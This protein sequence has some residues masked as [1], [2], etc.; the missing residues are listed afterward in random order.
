MSIDVELVANVSSWRW[1][2]IPVNAVAAVIRRFSSPSSL[3]RRIDLSVEQDSNWREL[4][5]VTPVTIPLCRLPE[6]SGRL[7]TRSHTLTT[8]SPLEEASTP[9]LRGSLHIEYTPS[10]WPSPRLPSRGAA[11]NL[12]NF[13]ALSALVYSLALSCGCSAGLRDL[14]M[15]ECDVFVGGAKLSA[16]LESVFT[17]MLRLNFENSIS[18]VVFEFQV[19]SRR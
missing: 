2:V 5:N 12:S 8:P 14:G 9:I 6:P 3:I 15:T 19:G 11:N 17:F 10:T 13:T 1:C 4:L 7:E 16:L 18:K